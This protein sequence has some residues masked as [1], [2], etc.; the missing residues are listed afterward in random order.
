MTAYNSA[1]YIDESISSILNQT[2]KDWEFVAVNDCSTD[3]TAQIIKSYSYKDSRV[4]LINNEINLQPAL[5]RNKALA[6]TRGEYIA[7]LD[8][9]DIAFPKRLELQSIF[10]ND[11]PEISLV[12]CAAEIINDKGEITG[13]KKTITNFDQLKFKLIAKN[14]IIH[15]GVM[16]RKSALDKVGGYNN[17]YLH[18]EDYKLYS[19]LIKTSKITNLPDFLIKY[20]HSPEAISVMAPTRKMQLDHA[21]AIG[22]ENISNYIQLPENKAR[23]LI[24]TLNNQSSSIKSILGSIKTYGNLT[25][26]Y[27]AKED[28]DTNQARQI[29]N[30]Y[31]SD[32]KL[33]LARYIK[34][35][36]PWLIKTIKF[37][38]N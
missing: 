31:N 9:D 29:W 35:K 6:E 1:R 22:F 38:K 30:I 25:R 36:F 11:N 12:G 20:R 24:N 5:S 15:S 10:L 34:S 13:R 16:Y 14:P 7:I 21:L 28:L 8:S 19:D 4:K 3:N 37:F 26:A 17:N 18:S 23:E 33:L 32:K 2:F 27:V